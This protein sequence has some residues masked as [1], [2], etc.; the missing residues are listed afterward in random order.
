[1][2]S[3]TQL[4]TETDSITDVPTLTTPG[5]VVH[6]ADSPDAAWWRDAVIYQIYPR[7]FADADGDGMGDLPG[8][9][10]RLPYLRD[11]GVDAV[12]L[13][14]F[15]VSP[16]NDAGYDVADYRDIDPLFGT[17][18]DADALIGDGARAGPEGASS[19]WCPTTPPTEH[20]W[21]QAA[22]A[23]GPGSPERARYIFRDGRGADGE[24]P[25]N[26]WQ[27]RLRRPRLDPGH[28]GRRHAGPVVPAP[29]R[30]HPA[31]P[32]LGPPRGGRPSSTTSCGSGSTGAST[33]SGSTSPT[34]WSRR[35]GLPDW[36]PTEPE[37]ATDG[38][39][40][41]TAPPMWDQDGV[42]EIY[43]DW[44]RV[45]D[46]LRPAD[47]ILCA[48]AWVDP[49]ATGSRATCAPTRCTR[50]STSTSSTPHWDA[51]A[52]RDVIDG[53]AAPPTTTS[54]RRPPGCCRTTT[55]CGTPPGSGSTVA[56][57]APRHRRRR[58]PAGCRAR[59]APCARRHDC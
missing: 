1:M 17:L 40:G 55:S 34:A 8:I 29:V 43:R 53:V 58:P 24:Q 37:P 51:T 26:N 50:R 15:Y 33:A 16:Q 42:H 5:E 56:P 54:A 39:R 28:R 32:Q 2:V 38:D 11:L 6:G 45:L 41:S 3:V 25:P 4:T 18:A 13:C 12:W 30:R 14:P 47:R 49:G 36:D 57:A 20:A 10:A 52:L 31:R 19:T 48:E 23:A 9:T 22:L 46:V 21:F 59:P 7:S 44:R 27:S 35:E